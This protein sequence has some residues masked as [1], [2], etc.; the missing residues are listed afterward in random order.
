MT[1]SGD[2]MMRSIMER[3]TQSHIR[4]CDSTITAY[5]QRK[6]K[7]MGTKKALTSAS[8]KML[9]MIHAVLRRG[10]PFAA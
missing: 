5:F 10:T 1:K 9:A 4:Y 7:E 8:R 3:V 2:P 6:R